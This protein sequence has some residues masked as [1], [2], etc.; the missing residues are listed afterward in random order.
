MSAPSIAPFDD[1]IAGPLPRVIRP[2]GSPP[3]P[4]T[5][6]SWWWSAAARRPDG[7]D[8]RRQ[9]RAHRRPGRAEPH[10]R[11]LRQLRLHP[12]QVLAPRGPGGVSGPRWGKVRLHA[13][14]APRVDFTALMTRVREMRAFSS[15]F[16]A[17][18][19][20]AGAGIDVF[21]GDARFV[22]SRR[23]RGRWPA[24]A[25][26]QG[27]DRHRERAGDPQ[28]AGSGRRPLPDERNRVRVDRTPPPAG[29]PRCRGGELR[30]G[31]GVSP[32]RQRRGP[33]SDDG[34]V[35]VQTGSGRRSHGETVEWQNTSS[36]P[37][38]V[39]ADA[40]LLRRARKFS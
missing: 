34:R 18:A 20:A 17:V 40:R 12:E 30:T 9:G 28:H 13:R 3:A 21:L 8:H 14:T 5:C 36:V 7:R 29:L 37:H 15:S 1:R 4:R 24:A 35:E 6:T 11:H 19:V 27:P 25:L 2:T 39:T 23:G 33:G 32:A 10:R 26:R 22:G 31:P 16:D 38:P